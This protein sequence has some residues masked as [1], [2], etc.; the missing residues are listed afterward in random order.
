[1]RAKIE[2]S[3]LV[4]YVRENEDK[5]GGVERLEKRESLYIYSPSP[6]CDQYSFGEQKSWVGI[7]TGTHRTFFCFFHL[8]LP[9]ALQ[10]YPTRQDKSEYELYSNSKWKYLDKT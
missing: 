5:T 1:M 6:V 4:R 8:F 10:A 7:P 9:T 3:E 2:K